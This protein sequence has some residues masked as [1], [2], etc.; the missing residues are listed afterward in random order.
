[1]VNKIDGGEIGRLSFKD[2]AD[3]IKKYNIPEDVQ[4]YS[5]SEWECG[6]THCGMAFYNPVTNELVFTQGYSYSEYA[7]DY[8]ESEGWIR[9]ARETTIQYLKDQKAQM[10]EQEEE[11]QKEW[12]KSLKENQLKKTTKTISPS[13]AFLNSYDW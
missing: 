4:L 7:H 2:L 13:E 10:D 6:P 3:F 1:M 12:E 8:P 9:Y 11:R 5:D